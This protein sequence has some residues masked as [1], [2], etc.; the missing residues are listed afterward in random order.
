MNLANLLASR[1][2]ALCLLFLIAIASSLIFPRFPCEIEAYRGMLWT[3]TRVDRL[4]RPN[5][6]WFFEHRNVVGA[7]SPSQWTRYRFG[8]PT[9]AITCDRSRDSTEWY[10]RIEISFVQL[11]LLFGI[12]CA[13][14]LLR[15]FLDKVR[16]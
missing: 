6:D 13:F 10:V 9:A 8:L 5:G 2:K 14:L 16:L 15:P 11:N 4:G 1:K 7:K 12:V 3:S